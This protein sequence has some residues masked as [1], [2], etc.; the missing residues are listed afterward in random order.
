MG[1]G[2][3]GDLVGRLLP[4]FGDADALADSLRLLRTLSPEW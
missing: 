3:S 1:V 4:G 2:E